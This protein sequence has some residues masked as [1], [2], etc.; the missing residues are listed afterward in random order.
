MQVGRK[1]IAFAKDVLQ[2]EGATFAGVETTHSNHFKLMFDIDGARDTYIMGQRV[3][4]A[5]HYKNIRAQLRRKV[6]E[7]RLRYGKS[8]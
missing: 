2:E 5:R 3:S 6:R 8:P 7:A 4:G 1:L